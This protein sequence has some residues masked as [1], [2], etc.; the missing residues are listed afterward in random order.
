VPET[1]VVQIPIQM[2]PMLVNAYLLVGE[3]V[4][5]VD[6]GIPG[7]HDLVL[8]AVRAAGREPADVS[9][10]LLTHGHAD[11]AGSADALRRLTGAKIA[12]GV[13]DA[14]PASATA[15]LRG[16]GFLGGLVVRM[17]QR[18]ARAAVAR[19]DE[20]S[21]PEP[22]V[23][24][25]DELDLTPY[26][27]DAIAVP[28]LGHS[29]DSLTVFTA[30]GDAIVGD[31]IGGGGLSK[32]VPKRGL[33]YNDDDAMSESIRAIIARSPRHVYD[34]HDAGPFTLAEMKAAF[35]ELS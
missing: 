33:L 12:I 19:A 28:T 27:V 11:H 35:P 16:R 14:D 34:G 2:G 21:G 7:K 13:E 1:T 4:V 8:D 25:S 17:I 29:P 26:G 30:A 5:A 24:V 20:P 18:R 9:L 10:I 22:D 32:R 15:A 3:R 23:L 31:L 6:T